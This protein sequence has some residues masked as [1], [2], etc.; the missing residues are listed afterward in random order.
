MQMSNATVTASKNRGF[1]LIELLIY[2]GLYSILI[3][4]LTQLMVTILD[5]KLESEN[6]TALQSESR[7]LQ[8]RLLY[9]IRRADS[10]DLPAAAGESSPSLELTID[11]QSVTYSIASDASLTLTTAGETASLSSRLHVTAFSAQKVTSPSSHDSV[12]ILLGL[13][14][15]NQTHQGVDTETIEFTGST[16]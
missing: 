8:N 13:E 10:V 12:V 11:G 2:F 14:A 3:V 6:R 5:A 1:T 15:Q 9:D 4:V 16:R 7:Y